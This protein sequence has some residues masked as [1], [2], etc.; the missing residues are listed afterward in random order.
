MLKKGSNCLAVWAQVSQSPAGTGSHSALHDGAGGWQSCTLCLQM[1]AAQDT[2]RLDPVA[3]LGNAAHGLLQQVL[4]PPCGRVNSG[5]LYLLI[6]RWSVVTRSRSNQRLGMSMYRY[7]MGVQQQ[8]AQVAAASCLFVFFVD[9]CV[10]VC[11]HGWSIIVLTGVQNN[12]DGTLWL[13]WAVA[14][15]C[16]VMDCL[17]VGCCLFW[18]CFRCWTSGAGPCSTPGRHGLSA[19]P[20][21]EGCV[22][23]ALFARFCCSGFDLKYA[24]IWLCPPFISSCLISC[25]RDVQPAPDGCQFSCRGV[26]ANGA[27]A[28]WP[29]WPAEPACTC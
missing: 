19:T 2:G 1:R 5:N 20:A 29:L 28:S 22:L 13:G 10:A 3:R 24:T 7:C 17:C 9:G 15:H 4:R 12:T 6:T 18:C 26:A 25:T 27:I 23:N 14:L 21:P 16:C 11:V 8:M